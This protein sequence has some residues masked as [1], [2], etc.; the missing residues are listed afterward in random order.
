MNI[1]I[2]LKRKLTGR[3]QAM[4]RAQAERLISL[5]KEQARK[6][7]GAFLFELA[8]HHVT[9]FV[10]D[11]LRRSERAFRGVPAEKVFHEMLA[12][13]FWVM[14]NEMAGGK[15]ALLPELHEGYFRTYRN[16][17]GSPEERGRALAEKYGRY[18]E[19]W[20]DHT[21]HQD[22][23]GLCVA[24]NL[25]GEEPSVLT[26][27]RCFWIIRFAHD[28]ADDIAPVRAAFRRKFDPDRPPAAA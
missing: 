22:E 24:Q 11:D 9:E 27:S 16:A 15:S 6:E 7:L 26:R 23:F 18:A 20:D 1:T 5:R 3:H 8:V 14:D 19:E 10:K 13:A 2:W 28:V 21:G 4:G 12:V 25:F 17:A